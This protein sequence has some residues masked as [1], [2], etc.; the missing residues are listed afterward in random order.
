NMLAGCMELAHTQTLWGKFKAPNIKKTLFIET[1]DAKPMLEARIRGLLRGLGIEDVKQLPDFH[2]ARLGPFDLVKMQD[3][4]MPVIQHFK[5][6]FVVLTT[7]QG[8]WGNRP[9]N[10][11]TEMAEVNAQFRKIEASVP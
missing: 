9:G 7:L 11:Q 10:Q 5:P 2:Y 3:E 8:P 6:D 4:L 1:E